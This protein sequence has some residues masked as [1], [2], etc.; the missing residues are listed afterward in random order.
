MYSS[1]GEIGGWSIGGTSLS[2]GN[3][4]LASSGTYAINVNSNFM[5]DFDGKV[6]LKKLIVDG[7]E[8]DFTT[9]FKNA[10]SLWAEWSGLN[11]K[12]YARF[13]NN[14]KLTADKNLTAAV[15]IGNVTTSKGSFSG[16]Y[17]AQGHTI[18]TTTIDGKGKEWKLT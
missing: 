4:T 8:V 5:V 13:Y 1:S 14:A 17:I 11:L 16:A 15:T 2:S 3:V 12:V 9:A 7:Q 10:V 6:W 18:V